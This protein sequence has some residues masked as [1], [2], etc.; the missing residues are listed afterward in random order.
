MKAF[1]LIPKQGSFE[2]AG[3]FIR[4]NPSLD[5]SAYLRL[6]IEKYGKKIT[7]DKFVEIIVRLF[8]IVDDD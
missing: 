7:S 6:F 2:K 3:K 5:H 4:E 1:D 8:D